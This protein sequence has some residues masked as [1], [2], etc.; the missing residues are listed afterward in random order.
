MKNITIPIMA[1][2]AP[3]SRTVSLSRECRD[4]VW[5]LIIDAPGIPHEFVEVN[6]RRF[7]LLRMPEPAPL[8][9]SI[10]KTLR[11]RIEELHI[12]Y[13]VTLV[14]HREWAEESSNKRLADVFEYLPEETRRNVCV[15]RDHKGVLHVIWRRSPT[16]METEQMARAW[17]DIGNEAHVNHEWLHGTRF[18]HSGPTV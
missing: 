2:S 13:G 6:G 18:D 14:R 12:K 8:P 11:D 4:G 7:D 15:M 5:G 9:G 3:E 16:I 10:S 17:R 1:F